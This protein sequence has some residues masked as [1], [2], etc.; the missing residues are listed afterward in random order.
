MCKDPETCLRNLTF[1]HPHTHP[2]QKSH[3]E[4]HGLLLVQQGHKALRFVR[5]INTFLAEPA[6]GRLFRTTKTGGEE[7]ELAK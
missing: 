5:A 6:W 4:G 7:I 1:A 2:H 3:N